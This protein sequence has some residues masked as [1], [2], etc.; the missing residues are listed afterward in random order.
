MSSTACRHA[1]S[2]VTGPSSM[3]RDR[4]AHEL[5]GVVEQEEVGVEDGGLV[6]GGGEGDSLPR[7]VQLV[8]GSLH[9]GDEAGPL[10]VGPP[11]DAIGRHDRSGG[12]EGALG[13]DTDSRCR[14]H[15]PRRRRLVR[16]L[17]R[18]RVVV[19]VA[20]HQR[21]DRGQRLA[22]LAAG[23]LDLDVMP[24]HRPDRRHRADAAGVDQLPADGHVADGD[25]GVEPADGL[26]EA[27]RRPCVQ[28]MGVVEGDL[29]AGGGRWADPRQ[30][31][32]G[33]H[34]DT[35]PEELGLD[36]RRVGGLGRHLGQRRTA[37]GGDD[38]GDEAFDDRGLRQH[39]RRCVV[40]GQLDGQFGAEH[41]AAEVHEH[42]HAVG[43]AGALDRGP[44][45]GG[46]GAEDPT[47]E[48]GRDL[49]GGPCPVHHLQCQ[50]D[51]GF[52]Q[53]ATVGDDDDADHGVR[54]AAAASRS[55]AAE[56]APGSW[57]PALRSP[58]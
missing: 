37:G 49:D 4:G 39:D 32:V 17:G 7:G 1:S 47:I 26:D 15:R 11:G 24:G 41:G 20:A 56:V 48:P 29:D 2:A 44:D 55:S 13:S 12:S 53:P 43:C 23:G 38:G 21:D 25:F 8:A 28:A 51:G 16:R 50:F 27:R 19:E 6:I 10:V 34:R 52:G 33:R 18:R 5:V 22:C 35:D 30:L 14:R 45:V 58:R 40:A 46:V 31:A 9:G 42:E 57:C 36:L 3:N 54:V